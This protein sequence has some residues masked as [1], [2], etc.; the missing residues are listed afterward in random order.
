MT[1]SQKTQELLI[2][3]F[4][5]NQIDIKLNYTPNGIKEFG[6]WIFTGNDNDFTASCTYSYDNG[7]I[8][9]LV[10]LTVHVLNGNIKSMDYKNILE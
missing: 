8:N 3:A 10:K 7:I 2:N 9:D 1:V 6:H 4:T 5:N